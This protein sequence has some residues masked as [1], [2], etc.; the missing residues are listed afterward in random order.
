[1]PYTT[2]AS[3]EM[4]DEP[5][6]FPNYGILWGIRISVA[7]IGFIGIILDDSNP[8]IFYATHPMHRNKGYMKECLGHVLSFIQD[9]QLCKSIS[10]EIYL[11]NI[12]SWKVL[13]AN[14][15]IEKERDNYKSYLYKSL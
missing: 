9:E 15:F 10:T 2:A 11:E 4:S 12:A 1:M 6:L 13:L 8:L 3:L 7:L 14:G 5:H